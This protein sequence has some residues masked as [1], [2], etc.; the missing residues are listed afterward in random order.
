MA[1]NPLGAITGGAKVA[2][3]TMAG[4]DSREKSP[5]G[6]TYNPNLPPGKQFINPAV[7]DRA[8]NP[9]G[10]PRDPNED[11]LAYPGVTRADGR[12]GNRGQGGYRMDKPGGQGPIYGDGRPIYGNPPPIFGGGPNYPGGG[13]PPIF[14]YD[15]NQPHILPMPYPGGPGQGGGKYDGPQYPGPDYKGP[16]M[17]DGTIPSGASVDWRNRPDPRTLDEN[18]NVRSPN[19]NGP[20]NPPPPGYRGPVMDDG[21]LPDTR[22]VEPPGQAGPGGGG[23]WD[24]NGGGMH[25]HDW[26]GQNDPRYNGQVRPGG[27]DDPGRWTRPDVVP[28]FD[29]NQVINDG[30]GSEGPGGMTGHNQDPGYWRQLQGGPQDY[31]RMGEVAGQVSN[32]VGPMFGGGS[33]YPN[34]VNDMYGGAK[35]TRSKSGFGNPIGDATAIGGGGPMGNLSKTAGPMAA[36]IAPNMIATS[37]P[38]A[39]GGGGGGGGSYGGNSY[40]GQGGYRVSSI[41]GG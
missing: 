1:F 12:G 41:Y 24:N 2:A 9:G 7:G 20:R 29:P 23:F 31:R 8:K 35:R 26:R 33:Y 15:P 32:Q 40:N 13:M 34:N 11:G 28:P 14:N 3:S 37:G 25:T 36:N 5:A 39:I 27:P 21:S 30:W 4:G 38:P 19:P 16:L 17:D 22:L 10:L 18:G 6:L